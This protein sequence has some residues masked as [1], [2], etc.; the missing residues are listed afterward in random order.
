MKVIKILLLLK[1][2]KKKKKKKRKKSRLH[3]T[4]SGLVWFGLL[5]FCVVV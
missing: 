5:C 3:F 2:R 1:K 4:C